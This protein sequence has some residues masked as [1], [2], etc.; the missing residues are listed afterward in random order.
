MKPTNIKEIGFGQIPK[1]MDFDYIDNDLIFYSD[2]KNLPFKE[3][4]LKTDMITIAVCLQ[5]KIQLDINANRFLAQQND[6]LV[7]LPNAYIK[8]TLLSPDFKCDI[9]CLSTRAAIDFIP[10]NKLWNKI[11]MLSTYPIIHLGNEDLYVFELYMKILKAKLETSTSRYKKE[12]LYSIVK[13]CLLELLGYINLNEPLPKGFSRKEILFKNFI[14]LL[15]GQEIRS[16]SLAWYSDKLFVSPK[17]L[18][19]VCKDV[20]G[21]IGRAHV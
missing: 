16:R 14:K 6:I 7:C 9:L 1:W 2:V 21:K 5:G 13:T 18:S 15:S 10:E 3:D 4:V 8:N 11:N 19:T 17:Y 20:S 12:I